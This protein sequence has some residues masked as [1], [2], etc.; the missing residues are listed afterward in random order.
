MRMLLR[1]RVIVPAA[2]AVVLVAVATGTAWYLLSEER[3]MGSAVERVL[4]A[5]T[6]LPITVGRASWNG[7]RLRLRDVRVP[8]GPTLPLDV[9]IGQLDIDAGIMALVSP[10]GR[11]IS[12]VATSTSI[13]LAGSRAP[14]GGTLERLRGTLLAFLGWPVTI[15]FRGDRVELQTPE[16]AFTVDVA[17][18]KLG[19]GV[20]AALTVAARDDGEP[21]RLDVRGAAALGRSVDLAVDVAGSTRILGTLWPDLA[22][23]ATAVSGRV[24]FQLVAGGVL[25]AFGR[26]SLGADRRTTLDF[27]SRYDEARSDLTLSRL[28]LRI[29]EDVDVAGTARLEGGETGRRLSAT[30]AGGVAG[31]KVTVTG[32]FEPADLAFQADLTAD[33]VD[34]ARARRLGLAVPFEASARDVRARVNG[35]VEAGATTARIDAA[36]GRLVTAVRPDA[37]VGASLLATVTVTRGGDGFALRRV[38]DGKL[39]LSSEGK[40]W[41]TATVTSAANAPWPLSVDA[42]VGDLARAAPF[43]PV[44]ATLSGSAHVRGSLA[45]VA[46][47]TFRGSLEARMPRARF[48]VGGPIELSDTRLEAPITVG[49]R[50]D[51]P[52]GAFGVPRVVAYGLVLEN[53]TGRASLADD[54]AL[55]SDLL[56]TQYGGT[57]TGWVDATRRSASSPFRGR[58]EAEGVDLARFVKESGSTAAR[59]TGTVRYVATVQYLPDVG[60]VADARIESTSGGEV[61]IDAIEGLLSS[62]AV[63]TESTGVLRRTLENLRVFEYASLEGDLRYRAGAGFIDLSLRG[64]KRLGVFPAPVEALNFKNVPLTLLVRT[65]T[66]EGRP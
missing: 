45:S 31:S 12:L 28:V 59:V 64:K 46:P 52:A 25:S 57:G 3:R 6:G 47:P 63:Q 19:P 38:Q 2:V 8:A 23:L 61:S 35:H 39:G 16:G 40:T 41:L 65:L 29:G 32:S 5:R 11:T 20:K 1:R 13:T 49:V 4:A 36:A 14:D 26:L 48:Q 55:L 56:Y 9:R 22:A 66:K 37:A 58:F 33:V 44:T 15:S 54:R 60:L 17:G 10:A 42:S 18:D 43:L 24:Q 27:T 7:R 50:G 62:E 30:L 53:L 21:L 34:S 51:P